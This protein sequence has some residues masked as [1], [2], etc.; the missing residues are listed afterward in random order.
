MSVHPSQPS[1]ATSQVATEA[2]VEDEID[3]RE[4]ILVLA[5][6]WREIVAIT[7]LT[8]VAAVLAVLLM[9]LVLPPEYEATAVVAIAPVRSQVTFEERFLTL[10]PEDLQGLAANQNARRQALLGL[11]KTGAVAQAVI[12]RLGDMLSEE[13]RLPANL[14]EMVQAELAAQDNRRAESDL[15]QIQA[16]ADSPQKAAAIATAWAEEYVRHVNTLYGQLPPDLVSSVEQQLDDAQQAYEQAQQELERFLAENR[17][18]QLQR[19]I[20]EKRAVIE[21]L[22]Q[23]RQTALTSLVNAELEARQQIIAAYINALA[24]NQVLAFNKEQEAKRRLF[25][26]L[27]DADTQAKLAVFDQQVKDRIETLSQHYAER[28]KLVRLLEDAQALRRQTEQ[29]GA[30]SVASNGLALLLLKAQVYAT[31]AGLP[32]DLQVAVDTLAAPPQDPAAQLADLDALIQAIETRMTQLDVTIAAESRTLFENRG[33][34]LLDAQRPADDPLF[35]AMVER[36]PDLFA[37]GELAS[38]VDRVGSDTALADLGR[39]RTQELLQ[40]EGLAELPTYMAAADPI[41]QAID[42]LEQEILAL[43]S[44]REAEAARKKELTQ[45]RDLAWTTL[46]TLRNK[47]AE[48]Q[49]SSTAVNT[50]VRFAAPAVEPVEPAARIGLL[51]AMALAGVVGLMLSIFIVFLANLM[52][53]EPPLGRPRGAEGG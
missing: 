25:S 52:E 8:V 18:D 5:R 33:Y 21:N 30:A 38:L 40:L 29:G 43:E 7:L 17:L 6:W 28:R 9:R 37:I 35:A 23:S 1:P 3:L 20:E 22:Y 19:Q 14:L 26:A 13:E 36:Y 41:L 51:T 16:T 32:G 46:T 27:A 53:V 2:W 34:T 31:S 24:T 15:I 4:Y 47:V 49:L 44:Q 48:L 12:D 42:T 10:S 11:V 45:K 50:E 39:Q